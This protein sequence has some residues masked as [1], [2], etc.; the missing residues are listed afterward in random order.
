MMVPDDNVL[1]LRSA[2]L[3]RSQARAMTAVRRHLGEARRAIDAVLAGDVDAVFLAHREVNR[4]MGVTLDNRLSTAW[5]NCPTCPTCGAE[6][7]QGRCW[8][9]GSPPAPGSAS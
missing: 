6:V 3:D 8:G 9:C 5:P 4:A 1:Q 7:S 2:A